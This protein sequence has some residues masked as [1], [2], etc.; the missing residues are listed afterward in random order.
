MYSYNEMRIRVYTGDGG[1][2][3]VRYVTGLP[4]ETGWEI[5]SSGTAL[6]M[7]ANF[8]VA[9]GCTSSYTAPTLLFTRTDFEA[10]LDV[11]ID[12]TFSGTE[13]GTCPFTYVI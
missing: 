7:S 8:S 9:V 2:Y 4:Y 3:E 12:M 1:A 6:E 13:D 10:Y 11:S 5:Y